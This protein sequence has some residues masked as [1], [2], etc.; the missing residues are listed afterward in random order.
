[1]RLLIKQFRRELFIAP[2]H[3]YP[4][5]TPYASALQATARCP[6]VSVCHKSAFY[7]SGWRDQADFRHRGVLQPILLCF[8]KRTRA[9]PDVTVLSA[10]NL[11]QNCQLLTAEIWP[12]HVDRRKVMLSVTS[13][14]VAG[15]AKLTIFATIDGQSVTSSVQLC[16]HHGARESA[17]RAGPSAT[18]DTRLSYCST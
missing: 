17:R 8:F 1:M 15:R 10:G 4:R 5:V 7:L 16:S 11:S 12:R 14:T 6:S 13:W 18:A 2:K 9:S 3:F